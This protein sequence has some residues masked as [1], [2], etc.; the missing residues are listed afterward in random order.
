MSAADAPDVTV[1]D[2]A[3]RPV[4]EGSEQS[5]PCLRQEGLLGEPPEEADR[6]TELVE[7][8]AARLAVA[9]VRFESS[10]IKR[11]EPILEVLSN[12]FHEF[13]ARCTSRRMV[14]PFVLTT[15]VLNESTWTTDVIKARHAQLLATVEK[16]WR[17]EARVSP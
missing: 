14:S 17:V 2:S 9:E 3:A 13:A 10:A 6:L 5:V 7:V 1:E 12:E 8:G 16:H 4:P 11:R 15:Q